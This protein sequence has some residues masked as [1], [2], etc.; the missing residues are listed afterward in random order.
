[1]GFKGKEKT[2]KKP[3][4]YTLSPA[5]LRAWKQEKL[6]EA[7]ARAQTGADLI[8]HGAAQ[9]LIDEG[10]FKTP[11]EACL[12]IA[13]A[14][15]EELDDHDLLPNKVYPDYSPDPTPNSWPEE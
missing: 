8:L 1:M 12:F 9:G 14:M 11:R 6:N 2:M 5:R 15:V 10:V 7:F 3:A 4:G 13:W